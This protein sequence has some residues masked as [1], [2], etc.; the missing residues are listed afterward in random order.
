MKS[1]SSDIPDQMIMFLLSSDTGMY[2]SELLD[3]FFHHFPVQL[4]RNI[5]T[6]PFFRFQAGHNKMNLFYLKKL[7]LF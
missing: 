1:P 6:H 3:Q 5:V 2:L 4:M 7:T